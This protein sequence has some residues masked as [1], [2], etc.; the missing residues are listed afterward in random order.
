VEQL[1]SRYD[2]K[3][4]IGP[5]PDAGVQFAWHNPSQGELDALFTPTDARFLKLGPDHRAVARGG[6]TNDK[7]FIAQILTHFIAA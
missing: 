1:G 5:T 6:I 2:V 7:D 3:P 4:T